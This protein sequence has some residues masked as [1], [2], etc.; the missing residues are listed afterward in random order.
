MCAGAYT[1]Q[2]NKTSRV[3]EYLF[4]IYEF[5]EIFS[6]NIKLLLQKTVIFFAPKKILK[7]KYI[8]YRN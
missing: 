6:R 3:Q 7:K 1:L 2:E 8:L 4:D 5:I